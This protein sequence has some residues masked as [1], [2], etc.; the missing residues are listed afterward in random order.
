MKHCMSLVFDILLLVA[1]KQGQTRLLVFDILLNSTGH[2]QTFL[3]SWSWNELRHNR[4]PMV[5]G[6]NFCFGVKSWCRAGAPGEGIRSMITRI[7]WSLGSQAL[8]CWSCRGNIV[9][10]KI[11]SGFVR[12]KYRTL[13]ACNHW[14]HIY[15]IGLYMN[16]SLQT[17]AN[18]HVANLVTTW[19][20][21]RWSLK[22]WDTWIPQQ[23]LNFD[24]PL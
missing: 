13:S 18:I 8:Q 14:W 6:P 9:T 4:R 5:S 23:H 10:W 11:L 21:P 2:T 19:A 17:L 15:S 24:F 12:I 3:S 20:M 22:H 16:L 1:W 7:K